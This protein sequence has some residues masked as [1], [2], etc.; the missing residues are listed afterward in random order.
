MLTKIVST[1]VPEANPQPLDERVA[2]AHHDAQNLINW[3]SIPGV[4]LRYN[5]EAGYLIGMFRMC[6][7]SSTADEA[8]GD[9]ELLI[10]YVKQTVEG[11]D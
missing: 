7:S 8:V 6:M 5:L 11:Q 9:I 4:A 10:G 2:N 3:L 1:H